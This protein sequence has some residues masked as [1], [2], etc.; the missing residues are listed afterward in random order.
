ME[1]CRTCDSPTDDFRLI[2]SKTG[3]LNRALDCRSCERC[4]AK[5]SRKARYGTEEGRKA[6]LSANSKYLTKPDTIERLALLGKQRYAEDLVFQDAAKDRAR[7]WRASNPER[8]ASTAAV[9]YQENKEKIRA[10]SHEKMAANPWLRLRGVIRARV[11]EA[12]RSEGDSK[13]GASVFHHLPYTIVQLKEHLERHPDWDPSW[14]SWSCYGTP[15]TPDGRAW[16]L[17]H[18]VPQSMFRYSSMTDEAFQLCWSLDNLRPL[19]GLQNFADGDKPDLFGDFRNFDEI[20]AALSSGV[21]GPPVENRLDDVFLRLSQARLGKSCP[22]SFTG[23]KYL[24]GIFLNRFRA[25]NANGQSLMD[26]IVD[27]RKVLR[28]VSH[29]VR[30]GERVTVPSILSNMKFVSRVPGHFFP[31]AAAAV[32]RAYAPTGLPVLDPFLGWGGRT[33]GAFCSGVPRIVGCDLQS[34]SVDGCRSVAS[35]FSVF[36]NVSAEFHNMDALRLLESTDER[37]GMIF[38]SPPYMASEDYGVESDAMRQDWLDRFVFPFTEACARRLAPGG[39]V[40]LHL[41]DLKGA[42]TFTAYHMSMKAAGFRQVARH[43]YGRTW[44]QSV[45]VYER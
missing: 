29:L 15:V 28:V 1:R 26:S 22:M 37:F 35:D 11:H 30:S 7:N 10:K 43:K 2:R 40:A 27:P 24:D 4:K 41:K 3:K 6:I 14:M 23:L 31:A 39:K 16:Q 5:E 38:S 32:W 19:D 13:N 18:T 20:L 8:K 9:Y 44:T 34:E 17:E 25:K 21:T 33:L 36:S 45:Y 42:P 12:I